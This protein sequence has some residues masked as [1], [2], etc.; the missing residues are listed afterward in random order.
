MRAHPEGRVCDANNNREK[1]MAKEHKYIAVCYDLYVKDEEG[2]WDLMESAPEERPFFFVSGMG[3]TL[4]DFEAA[5]APLEKGDKFEFVL[6][7]EQAYGEY[8]KEGVQKLSRKVFEIDG[9]LDRKRIYV[10]AVVPMR[11]GDGESFSATVTEVT[12]DSV[13][14]DM[15]HPLA[16]ETLRF[17]GEVLESREATANELEAMARSMV[18]GS[19]DGCCSDCDSDCGGCDKQC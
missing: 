18:K 2:E 17:V 15:N 10:G 3:M 16:G 13:T 19:C 5:I 11:S 4:D 14:I 7:P 8:V 12:E 1:Y 6:T 9:M